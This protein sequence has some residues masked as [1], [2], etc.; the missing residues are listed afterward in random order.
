MNTNSN[1]RTDHD[2][3][4]AWR[5]A[6][7]AD[8]WILEAVFAGEPA[9]SYGQ[10]KRDGFT[11]H[12][13]AREKT[14]MEQ[15]FPKTSHG[16]WEYHSAVSLWGPDGVSVITPFPYSSDAITKG[17][18]HCEVCGKDDVETVRVAFC[19]RACVACAPALRAKLETRGWCD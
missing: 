11:G 16:K 19:N 2:C 4:V 10:I 9:E 3:V 6:A 8:G 15:Y 7:I 17:P 18:R 13:C 1:D 12:I 14:K 5:D